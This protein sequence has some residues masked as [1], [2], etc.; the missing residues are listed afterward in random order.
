MSDTSSQAFGV[1]PDPT[2]TADNLFVSTTD[3]Q[4]DADA[5]GGASEP[6]PVTE[7]VGKM[8][9]L[10]AN[11]QDVSLTGE[12]LITAA[13]KGL[14]Y[15]E[16]TTKHGQLKQELEPAAKN[17]KQWEEAVQANPGAT[18]AAYAKQHGYVVGK[19][20]DAG[21]FDAF[22]PSDS[23]VT[24]DAQSSSPEMQ[25]LMNE[26]NEMKE[27]LS[28]ALS[29]VT[30]SQQEQKLV[31]ELNATPD[32][33]TKAKALA[34]ARG[35]GAGNLDLALQLVRQTSPATAAPTGAVGGG[36]DVQEQLLQLLKAGNPQLGGNGFQGTPV[37]DGKARDEMSSEE[38]TRATWEETKKEL[39]IR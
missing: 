21:Y 28:Q 24:P 39:G 34:E 12:E 1:N 35:L 9:Q 26:M 4:D 27:Q 23:I 19:V 33:I 5:T 32:E 18:F 3:I 36:G 15:D 11:H 20:N 14:N 8:F 38:K 2:A 10:R 37:S 13:Q 25:A 17:W 22:D 7:L 16:L 31:Q 29:G 6:S 30:S